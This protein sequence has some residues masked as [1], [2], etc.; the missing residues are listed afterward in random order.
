MRKLCILIF[1]FVFFEQAAVSQDLNAGPYYQSLLMNNPGLSGGEGDGVMRMSYINYYPGQHFDLNSFYLSYDSYFSAL[2]GG[3]GFYLSQDLLG[4]I[5]NDLRGGLSYAYFLRAGKNLFINAGLT[6]SVFHRGYSFANAI[7]PDQIDAVG[8]V[9]LPSAE[10]LGNTGRTLF[11]VGAGFIMIS[12]RYSGGLAVNH[13]TEPELYSSA[14]Y[15]E[16][17][18]RRI[19]LHAESVYSVGGSEDLR[20]APLVLTVLQGNYFMA[21]GGASFESTRI[22][23]NLM[24]SVDNAKNT[25]LQTGV[26][27][28][29]KSFSLFYNYQF[30]L[31]S[32]N[33]MLPLSLMQQAGLAVGLNN[34]E[35]R[36][37]GGTIKFPKL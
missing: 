28:R 9:T 15:T 35:K 32:G 20:M 36:S 18:R 21:A 27:V 12:G 26:A 14:V 23:L 17:I 11:D 24:L 30:N 13:L 7:L 16:K 2:H 3:A 8:G 22:A 4:G 6:G 10:T 29:L 31:H 19:T 37:D 5:V 33:S 34:V 25:N 1:L